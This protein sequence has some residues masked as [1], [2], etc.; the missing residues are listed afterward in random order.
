[1]P[2]LIFKCPYLKGGADKSHLE[3]LVGYI[4]TRQGV[5]TVEADQRDRPATPA[6]IKMVEQLL[7]EFPLSR[8]L[9]EY[10]DYR[11]SP[12]LGSASAFLSRAVEDNLDQIAKRENYLE[13]IAKRPRAQRLGAHGLFTGSDDPVILDR[14]AEDVAHHPGNVWLPIISLRR[15]DAARL[16]YDNA[17]AWKTLLAS[18][19]MDMA[20]AMKIPWEDFRWYA[21]YHDEG[22]HPHVHM[23][24]YSADPA[25][26]FLTKEG[27]AQIKSG[28]VQKIFQQDL[29]ELYRQQTQ[30][31]DELTEEAH[32][33][34]GRLLAQMAEATTE[35]PQVE[36][37]VAYL[38]QRLK[39]LS[40]KKQYGYLKPELKNVVDQ[41]VDELARDD[42]VSKAFGLWYD[43]R[44]EVLRT[45]KDTLPPRVPLYQQKEFKR[46]KNVVIQEA[47]RLGAIEEAPGLIMPDEGG[48]ALPDSDGV[49]EQP[50]PSEETPPADAAPTGTPDQS[51]PSND[52]AR[53][54]TPTP[55]VTWSA[56]YKLA[57]SCL[58]GMDGY[59][60]DFAKACALLLEEARTGNALAMCDLGRMYAD[61]LAPEGA[62][63][64]PE[65]ET[66]PPSHWWYAKALAAFLSVEDGKPD[67]YA[68][69]RIG[70]L[71]ASGLGTVQDYGEAANWFQRS[72][73]TGYQY[74]QYALGGLYYQGK[75]V[76]QDYECAHQLYTASEAQRFPYAAYELGKMCR[77]GVGCPVDEASSRAHFAQAFEGFLHLAQKGGD[78]TLLYRLGSMLLH[79]VGREPDPARAKGYFAKAAQLGNPYAQYQL[80]KLLLSEAGTDPAQLKEAVGMLTKSAERG[81]AFAQ[82]ALGRLYLRGE[83]VPQDSAEAVRWF[84]LS[85]EQGNEYAQ[86]ALDNIRINSATRLLHALGELFLEQLPPPRGQGLVAGVDRKLL[87]KIREKKIAMGHKADD[88]VPQQTY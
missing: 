45:Y 38:A 66:D 19:A 27:I 50:N 21:A 32:A 37:L 84:T 56:R 75:G 55:N 64:L 41:I 85:A 3:N 83:G 40:G 81:D 80:A 67:R 53:K 44:E 25:K 15:E 33:A 54:K 59:P 72:A 12:T 76:A 10:E 4:A 20:A 36:Q 23:V 57:R 42:R 52:D 29:T 35:N 51:P 70:K 73:D 22:S 87:R 74:A 79:G 11:A 46:L 2:R 5:E 14:V 78:D 48:E 24:C 86:C 18:Y 65:G 88:H 28:L 8:A 30:R 71:Y 13:Y 77:D 7:K 34:L 82:Y 68:E 62:W 31:R 58:F 39:K 6:Q 1:M 69:Y 16:G 43:L 60:P 17:Q 26:G 61:G 49:D 47:L 63:A 9:F